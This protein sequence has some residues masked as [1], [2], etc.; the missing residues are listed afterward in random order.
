[1]L[2]DKLLHCCNCRNLHPL[3]FRVPGSLIINP[4]IVVHDSRGTIAVTKSSLLMLRHYRR[5]ITYTNR[6][7]TVRVTI[8][9]YNGA[10]AATTCT[11]RDNTRTYTLHARVSYAARL[12]HSHTTDGRTRVG[13]ACT[14]TL[15][16]IAWDSHDD[17]NETFAGGLF[18]AQCKSA[19]YW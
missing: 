4:L 15:V 18:G 12:L 7:G 8:S 14:G 5:A 17:G 2:H 11:Q 13:C 6:S 19:C 9:E 10:L 16:C 3:R 1:M